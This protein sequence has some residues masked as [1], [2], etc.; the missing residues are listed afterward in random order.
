MRRS[1]TYRAVLV[2]ACLVLAACSTPGGTG[3]PSGTDAEG[4]PER[5][6]LRVGVLPIVDV[7]P[8]YLAIER[9][10]F[11]AEGLTVVPEI[12]QGG[13]AA[14]PALQGGDL[15]L[16]YGNWVSFLLANQ[17]G[18]PLRAIADGVAAAPGFTELLA[19]PDSG[20]AGDPAGLAG[21]RIALNTLNNIGELAVRST[22]REAG[23]DLAAVELLEIPFPDMTATLDRGDVDVI[24]ASE[25]VPT[26]AKE[27]L[28][29]VVVADSFV[30]QMEAFPVAGYQGTAEFVAEHPNTIAAFRRALAAAA[31]LIEED[32]SLAVDIVPT[33]TSLSPEL[34]GQLAL[35]R[36]GTALEVGTLERVYDYLLEFDM[37]TDAL[38][39]PSLVVAGTATE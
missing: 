30:G 20:L 31:R 16:A 37:I 38:D 4:L 13:A 9:G 33:Y 3:G 2:T 7:A 24:W 6:E 26:I 15:D 34:A 32:P 22:L 39:V 28:G 5:T 14:I 36:Y 1:W 23:V 11:A 8:V 27:S 25:P 21:T 29:A 18:I 12:V 35:P 10:L 17:G 19:A